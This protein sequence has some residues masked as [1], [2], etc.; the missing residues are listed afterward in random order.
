GQTV[1]K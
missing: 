1:T